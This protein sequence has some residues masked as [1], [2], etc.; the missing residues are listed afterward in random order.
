M[1]DDFHYFIVT[2]INNDLNK[3]KVIFSDTA[4]IKNFNDKKKI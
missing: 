1:K 3:K 4:C 2:S